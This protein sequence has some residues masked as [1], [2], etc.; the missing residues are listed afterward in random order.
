MPNGQNTDSVLDEERR[1]LEA[2]KQDPKQIGP[3]FD[4][5][6]DTIYAFLL[7]RCGHKETAEDLVSLTFVKFLESREK[8]EWQNVKISALLF[9]IASNSLIDHWRKASTR[10]N[11]AL[12]NEEFIL[13]SADDPAWNVELN[14]T[15]EK[16]REG[17]KILSERDQE[18]LN[19]RFFGQLEAAEIAD[20]LG[21][22]SNHVAVLV[23]RALG[24]LRKHLLKL[25]V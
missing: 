18:I 3:I 4:K 19:L 10:Y 7:K 6:A 22:S 12:D 24:R 17:M 14:L 25:H 11:T 23:Y 1:M 16:I 20:S 15:A 13:P 8:I 2:F 21:I 9:R 5:Y